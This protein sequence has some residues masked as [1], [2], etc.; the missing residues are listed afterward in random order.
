MRFVTSPL[1]GAMLAC[2]ANQAPTGSPTPDSTVAGLPL[3][4]PVNYRCDS[5]SMIRANYRGKSVSL[6]WNG[7]AYPLIINPA[8][9]G[10]T[11]YRKGTMVWQLAGRS[12][13]LVE[14]GRKVATGCAPQ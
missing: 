6:Y 7:R 11:V 8:T 13:S 2:G 10:D 3:Q 12:A 9:T 4:G 1:L 14:R 5:G